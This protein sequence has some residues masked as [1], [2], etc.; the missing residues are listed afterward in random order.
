MES[1][2]ELL[3][4][5]VSNEQLDIHERLIDESFEA[6]VRLLD[7]HDALSHLVMARPTLTDEQYNIATQHAYGIAVR[8]TDISLESL[9][10]SCEATNRSL[11]D[12][13]KAILKAIAEFF[14]RIF[15]W[16]AEIDVVCSVT[17][18]RAFMLKKAAI[19]AR[20]RN[21]TQPF[22][23]L[24]RLHRY[25]RRG[26]VYLQDSIRMEYELK[27]LLNVCNVA[28]GDLPEDILRALDRMP[29]VQAQADKKLACVEIVENIPFTRLA[30]KFKM[31]PAPRERFSRDN[32][33]AT[34]PLMGGRSIF[35][36]QSDLR[37]KGTVG[38]RF[39]GFHYADTLIEQF[40][41]APSRQFDT[42][43]SLDIVKL[44][45]ILIEILSAVSRTNN[46]TMLAKVKKA[47]SVAENLSARIA[48]DESLSAVDRDYI[49]KT[50]NALMYWTIN[51]TRPLGNDAIS[52]CKAV[53]HYCHQ[54]LKVLR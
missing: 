52:V 2:L 36:F 27:S 40:A 48:T 1:E 18:R 21:P 16:I 33:Q 13:S 11:I 29:S 49:R 34:A 46:S 41:F 17:K 9:N 15:N 50:I 23:E 47:R 53:I 38:L 6:V 39:H 24:N 45:D 31:T 26:H 54:S 44:P 4:T 30:N 42:L 35:L 5:D 32:V 37:S 7:T 14:K 25:L 3:D 12:I 10:L 22:V 51:V 19:T 20:G 28:F 8:G 43:G